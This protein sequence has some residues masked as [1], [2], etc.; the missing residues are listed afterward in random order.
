MRVEYI[1]PFIVGITQV[2]ESSIGITPHR[3]SVG[4]KEDNTP[5]HDVS[6]I[7]G[8]SGNAFGSIVL[9]FPRETAQKVMAAMLG[10]EEVSNEFLA[11][12]VGELANMIAGVAKTI[13]A[14]QGIKTFI[15]IPRVI[16]GLSH[17]IHRPKEVPCVEIEFETEMG[18]LVLEVALKVL[19][20]APATSS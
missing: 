17:Y 11:D 19:Q 7:I 13:L 15:S 1:N 16:L 5:S 4:L 9:S 12:G 14:E 18:N 10:D 2:F 20:E 6:A 8:L 3:S